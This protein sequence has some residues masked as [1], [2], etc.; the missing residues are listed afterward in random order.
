MPSV[1]ALDLGGIVG[2][3]A[4][5][6]RKR[7]REE[8]ETA[9]APVAQRPRLGDLPYLLAEALRAAASR[10]ESIGSSEARALREVLG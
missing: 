10:V 7:R 5:P 6:S 9:E 1:A 8:E 4:R 3:P 2:S